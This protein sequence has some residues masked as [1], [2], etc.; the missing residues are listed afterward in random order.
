[1]LVMGFCKVGPDGRIAVRRVAFGEELGLLDHEFV[2]EDVCGW[3]ELRYHGRTYQERI[4]ARAV[5][6]VFLPEA[7]SLTKACDRALGS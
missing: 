4:S 2:D 1:M 5:S 3:I 7:T 6:W